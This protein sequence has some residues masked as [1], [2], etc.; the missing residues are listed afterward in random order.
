MRLSW[1]V[2]GAQLYNQG[3]EKGNLT[4]TGKGAWHVLLSCTK[5]CLWAGRR[6]ALV[7]ATESFATESQ[8]QGPQSKTTAHITE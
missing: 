7:F 6:L 5:G 2:T 1:K 8:L 4:P 3:R